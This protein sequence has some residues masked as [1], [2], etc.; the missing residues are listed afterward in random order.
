MKLPKIRTMAGLLECMS[1]RTFV[2]SVAK[3]EMQPGLRDVRTIKR[4]PIDVL[5][6]FEIASMESC[7]LEETHELFPLVPHNDRQ[8]WVQ[9]RIADLVEYDFEDKNYDPY[10]IMECIN[11]QT[12]GIVKDCYNRPDVIVRIRPRTWMITRLKDWKFYYSRV[13]DMNK[14]RGNV[15]YDK[16]MIKGC[17]VIFAKS[18]ISFKEEKEDVYYR[19]HSRLFEKFESTDAKARRF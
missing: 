13:S 11:R 8:N 3:V 1:L 16:D 2:D 4:K 18:D 12:M 19:G 14:V 6:S 7:Y 5:G 15:V 9:K 17:K 10:G